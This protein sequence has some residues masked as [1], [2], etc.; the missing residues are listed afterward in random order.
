MRRAPSLEM[1]Q[2]NMPMRDPA[3]SEERRIIPHTRHTFFKSELSSSSVF[4]VER[5]LLHRTFPR[6]YFLSPQTAQK[7]EQRT[8][9]PGRAVSKQCSKL[10]HEVK[11]AWGTWV[12]ALSWTPR[13]RITS[14]DHGDNVQAAR[15]REDSRVLLYTSPH[16]QRRIHQISQWPLPASPACGHHL[17]G[18]AHRSSGVPTSINFSTSFNVSTHEC[19]HMMYPH[20]SVYSQASMYPHPSIDLYP[21]A[22]T[23]TSMYPHALM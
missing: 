20:T 15:Q 17:M 2:V 18:R 6:H 11:G 1:R 4:Q 9:A 22:Y 14:E 5:L 16:L 12:T 10:P 23:H 7:W 19:I 13:Q 21:S 8:G 3:A